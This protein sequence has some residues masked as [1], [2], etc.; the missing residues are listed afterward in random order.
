MADGDR[1]GRGHGGGHGHVTELYDAHVDEVYRYVHRL[2][3]DHALAEDVTQDVFLRAMGRDDELTVAWLLRS[4]RN[5]LI[6]QVRREATYRDKL[7][8]LHPR[9]TDASDEMSGLIDD[10]RL[11][12]GLGRLRPDHR[13]VLMLHYVD[14]A[15][16]TEL[17][18]ALGRSYKGAE[19]LLS[20]A[21]AALRTELEN[22][23]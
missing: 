18:A 5:R 17:A 6:D 4:A 10:L 11:R 21:R 19:G 1:R 22:D 12:E 2:C 15:S 9:P 7:R 3:L 14:G 16:V 20:R 13:I 23:R 8:I